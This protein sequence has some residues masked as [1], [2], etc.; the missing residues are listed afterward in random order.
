MLFPRVLVVFDR[1]C[2]LCH[3][4]E[5]SSNLPHSLL[6]HF[7]HLFR[8]SLLPFPLHP[9]FILHCYSSA[10]YIHIPPIQH[11][12]AL[13]ATT[14]S[15]NKFLHLSCLLDHAVQML[16]EVPLYFN[17]CSQPPDHFPRLCAGAVQKGNVFS[18]I[19]L[20]I[21]DSNPCHFARFQGDIIFFAKAFRHLKNL[22]SL[23]YRHLQYL[24]YN[25]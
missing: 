5:V 19:L 18:I 21:C 6:I 3:G 17:S 1:N 14:L 22:L 16:L 2:L 7:L 8:Q 15:D 10:C 11:F 4:S 24:P 13:A 20:L 9:A 25:G 23:A 12:N